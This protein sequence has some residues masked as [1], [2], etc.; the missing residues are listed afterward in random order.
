MRPTVEEIQR[1]AYH[2]WERRGWHHGSDRDD[3]LASEKELTFHARYRTIVDYAID[4]PEHRVLGGNPGRRCRFCERTPAQTTFDA[5]RPIIPVRATLLT[6]EVCDECQLDWWEG[7]EHELR[8]FWSRLSG[9]ASPAANGFAW[10]FPGRSLFSVATFKALAASALVI[11]PTEE[12]RFFVDTLEWVSNPD[13]DA[14]DRLLDGAE[15]RVYRAP[16]LGER[17]RASLVRRIDDETPAP[18]MLYFLECDQTMV[19]VSLP[20]CLRDEDLDGR[21]IEHPERVPA[22]GY[23]HDFREARSVLLPLSVSARRMNRP[24]R[25]AALAC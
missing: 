11:M 19:Q 10:D 7:L 5:P 2:R 12:L 8:L 24:P 6:G 4:G 22:S 17:S 3:W 1:A 13:H 20:M 25:L 14:D 23:G 18:Y 16:F 21:A 15:C 9:E